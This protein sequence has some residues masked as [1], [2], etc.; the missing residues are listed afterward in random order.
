M[1]KKPTVRLATLLESIPLSVSKLIEAHT[2]IDTKH[3]NGKLV[4]KI[5]SEADD[6]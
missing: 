4:V 1:I 3:T 6:F 2:K 5:R